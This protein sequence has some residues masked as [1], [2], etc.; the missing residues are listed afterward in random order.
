[1]IRD[2]PALLLD[3]ALEQSTEWF[4]DFHG[5]QLS[6]FTTELREAAKS[7]SAESDRDLA[8]LGLQIA[9]VLARDSASLLSSSMFELVSLAGR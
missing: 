2:T 7:L 3:T 9:H 1:M 5:W 8:N 4:S 6:A